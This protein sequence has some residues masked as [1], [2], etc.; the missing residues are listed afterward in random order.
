MDAMRYISKLLLVLSLCAA[1]FP[2]HAELLVV[3]KGADGLFAP[4]TEEDT[5]KDGK[6]ISDILLKYEWPMCITSDLTN[7][8]KNELLAV[9]KAY[10]EE[11]FIEKKIQESL[12]TDYG[13]IF[14]PTALYEIFVWAEYA[15][16]RLYTTFNVVV[17]EDFRQGE[18]IPSH[19][20][21]LIG[22]GKQHGINYDRY[23]MANQF[24]INQEANILAYVNKKFSEILFEWD[25]ALK[26]NTESFILS[27]II[28]SNIDQ[29]S[30]QLIKNRLQYGLGHHGTNVQAMRS[31]NKIFKGLQNEQKNKIIAKVVALEYE[32]RELNKGLLL[33]G[34]E[35]IAIGSNKNIKKL[36]GSTIK[37]SSG[38]IYKKEDLG[39]YSISFGN[40]LF[41]GV[42][43]DP[44]ACAYYYLSDLGFG[45]AVLID[46]KGYV[47]HQEHNLFFISPLSSLAS[48]FHLGEF[49]HSRTKA[50][51]WLK[52]CEEWH[53]LSG[54]EGSVAS[55]KEKGLIV[56]TRNPLYHAE[57]FSDYLAKNGRIIQVG[58]IS[59]FTDEEKEFARE[60]MQGQKE[61]AKFYKDVRL[62]TP[63]INRAKQAIKKS[64]HL[65]RE[66]EQL[67][68]AEAEQELQ[69]VYGGS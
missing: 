40:S 65:R 26:N 4:M 67:E 53:Y 39:P 62:V 61:A 29:L 35:V 24:F 11:K 25:S 23:N 56:I 30:S 34:T 22:V 8:E 69:R 57:L 63:R 47:D 2:A 19:S 5:K 60:V 16:D 31:V 15:S 52:K 13:V 54:A 45:Y 17:L 48:L 18:K 21:P 44:T 38:K 27:N 46:K 64:K 12:G 20:G 66:K 50:A 7:T 32:A 41:A 59:K 51:V 1:V 42:V 10:A 36:I 43:T 9:G 28:K 68:R 14:V 33:R 37:L 6:V 58:N 3:K 55:P 49:F